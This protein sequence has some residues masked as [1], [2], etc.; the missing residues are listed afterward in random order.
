[1][2]SRSGVLAV[3]LALL[4]PAAARAQATITPEEQRMV[5]AQLAIPKLDP[6]K[7]VTVDLTATPVADIIET[8]AK[9]GG[10]TVRYHSG[11]TNLDASAAVKLSD[12]TIQDALQNV[13]TLRGLAFTVTSAKSVFIYPG[14]AENRAKYASAVRTFSVANANVSSLSQI[15]N[16]GLGNG[17]L[18]PD[19]LR[20]TIVTLN[21]SRTIYVRATPEVMAK[22]A[23]LIADADKR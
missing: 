5:D 2:T 10:I 14:T 20:P 3:V 19:D 18:G 4:F 7:I 13:L 16:Q 21:S 22:V 23:K 12:A 15:L 17:V 9:A 6:N 11:V 1:M 8:V